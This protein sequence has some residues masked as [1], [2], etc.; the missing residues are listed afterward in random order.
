MDG[1]SLGFKPSGGQLSNVA[2]KAC[3]KHNSIFEEARFGAATGNPKPYKFYLQ[4]SKVRNYALGFKPSGGQSSKDVTTTCSKHS[5]IFEKAG[6][7][8]ATGNPKPYKFFLAG[9]Q[10]PKLRFRF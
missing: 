2:S 6:F 9:E 3:S 10:G 5:S 7:G 1:A 8:A 4:R